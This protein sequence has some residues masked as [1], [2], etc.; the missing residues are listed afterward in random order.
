MRKLIIVSVKHDQSTADDLVAAGLIG[1]L[2]G[3]GS[4]RVLSGMDNV[5]QDV[6]RVVSRSLRQRG[7]VLVHPALT[8]PHLEP[9]TPEFVRVLDE[10]GEERDCIVVVVWAGQVPALVTEFL[11]NRTGNDLILPLDIAT[12]PVIVL[13]PEAFT[14]ECLGVPQPVAV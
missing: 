2:V 8:S 1:S 4:L 7:A 6:A 14:I 3:S 11:K 10:E 9:E 5:V 12:A 13:D